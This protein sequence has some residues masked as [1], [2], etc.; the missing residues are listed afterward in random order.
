MRE[1]SAR[2]PLVLVQF[3]AFD[4]L[5]YRSRNSL[6]LLLETR[7]E[8]LAEA[9]AKVEYPV[10]RCPAFTAKPADFVRAAKELQLEGIIAKRKDSLYESG[11][12]NGAWLKYQ[13][14]RSQKFVI[15]GYTPGNPFDALIVGYYEGPAL[16]FVGKV[17]NGF[18]PHTRRNVY[19]RF[20]ALK[21]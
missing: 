16:K 21:D 12:R 18:V 3:Y 10:L 14:N 7:R 6:R 20:D 4:I 19:K 17:R 5:S 8:L 15:G 2:H 11:R 9:L 13:I 1:S